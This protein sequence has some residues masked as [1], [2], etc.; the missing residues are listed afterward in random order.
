M[1]DETT[2]PLFGPDWSM[3]MAR[4]EPLRV[5]LVAIE[6]RKG[7][8]GGL[9]G[10][11]R[12]V[13]RVA[14]KKREAIARGAMVETARAVV[15]L[16]GVVQMTSAA[17]ME[18]AGAE[19]LQGAVEVQV[20][21]VAVVQ[22]AEATEATAMSLVQMVP[23]EVA[24]AAARSDRGVLVF[25]V[26]TT[27]T[28][29]R[30]DQ[31]IEL[32]VQFGLGDGAESKTWRFKPAVAISPGAQAVHGIS[33]EMLEGC[34]AFG[35]VV[36]EITKV[37]EEA[38]VLVGYNLVFDID[39]VSA[40]YERLGRPL[41]A[42]AKKTIIDPFRMWQQC[43]PRSL[44]HAHQ[45]FVGHTFDAAHSATADVAATGRV[46]NGM[47]RTFGLEAHDW[48]AIAG[49]CDPGRPSWVGPSRHLQWSGERVVMAFGKHSGT[50]L[51]QID[52]GYLKWMAERDFPTHVTQICNKAADLT[53]PEFLGWVKTA[54]G[55]PPP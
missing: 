41:P 23:V 40:E 32:C 3:P 42:W 9:E 1:R 33:M 51:H 27:G 8:D 53:E 19:A 47:L 30:R 28:D 7:M 36:E 55:A 44:V 22:A 39:M 2:L 10:K 20:V 17:V 49:V 52:R 5:E 18:A 15:E 24:E 11:K 46:L 12:R 16:A 21:D 13:G 14:G 54:F 48:R 34:P 35:D 50:P 25:D 26:E 4:I 29:R 31:V 37:F 45:R 6:P 43:E 38:E